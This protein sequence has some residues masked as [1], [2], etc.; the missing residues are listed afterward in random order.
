MFA[1]RAPIA[2]L[3]PVLGL[4]IAALALAGCIGGNITAEET[5]TQSFQTGA[6]P[7]IVVETFNGEIE[8][9][10]GSSGKV[11]VVA[12][13]RGSGFSR[14]EAEGDLENVEVSM[15]QSGDTI[16]IVARRT[17]GAFITGN[18]GASIRLSA[19]AAA[20]LE[21][22]SSNGALT[23]IGVSGDVRMDTSNGRIEVRD[24]AGRLDVKTSNGAIDIEAEEAVVD[25]NTSNG[26]ITFSGSLAEGSQ[27]FRTSNGAIDITLPAAA[28]FRID[29]STSNGRVS[30]EF[31]VDGESDDEWLRG[32][33]GE[34]P[35]T[36][37]SASSSN[38]NIRIQKGR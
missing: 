21:L 23:S 24:G 6:A 1:R 37:I 36:S 27:A 32:V 3:W 25:A 11:E 17:D 18:S 12:V 38:G 2:G 16:R 30:S 26:R 34:N 31:A 9:S 29:A 33:V 7:R 19:P 35:A 28:R 5:V 8:V 13:K 20:S 10:A 15:T 4:L 22:T 14:A